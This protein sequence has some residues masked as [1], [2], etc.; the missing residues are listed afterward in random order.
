M[1]PTPAETITQVR[2]LLKEVIEPDLQSDYARGRLGEIRA[3]LAQMEWNNAAAQLAARNAEL[4]QLTLDCAQ[5]AEE[6]PQ[7]QPV[8]A[9][10]QDAIAGIRTQP[11]TLV[12]RFEDLNASNQ[13]YAALLIAVADRIAYWGNEHPEDTSAQD[14]LGRLIEYFARDARAADS[15]RKAT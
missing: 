3:V 14:Q 5:W 12:P 6:S 1:R 4:A 11:P 2:R 15:R 10:L 7:R 9:D 13:T 8:L